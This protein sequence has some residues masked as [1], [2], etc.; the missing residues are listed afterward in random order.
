MHPYLEKEVKNLFYKNATVVDWDKTGLD[1]SK[2]EP[3]FSVRITNDHNSDHFYF[4][5]DASDAFALKW[6]QENFPDG[7][8]SLEQSDYM[9]RICWIPAYTFNPQN[10]TYYIDYSDVFE[11]LWRPRL[12]SVASIQSETPHCYVWDESNKWIPEPLMASPEYQKKVGMDVSNKKNV[13]LHAYSEFD[14]FLFTKIIKNLY[15]SCWDWD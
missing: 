4:S 9:Y 7:L 5:T 13:S 14:F 6:I 15:P 12:V 11:T 2:F 8:P 10:A 1:I 3:Y